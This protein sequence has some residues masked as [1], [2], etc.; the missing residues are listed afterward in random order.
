VSS[1]RTFA[2]LP[3]AVFI[4]PFNVDRQPGTGP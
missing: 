4:A 1:S 2:Q 3:R